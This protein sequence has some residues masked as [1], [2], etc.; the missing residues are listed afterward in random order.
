AV[1]ARTRHGDQPGNAANGKVLFKEF[2]GKCH[3]MQAAGSKG[4]IG[5]NLDTDKVAYTGVVSA[6]IQGVGGIQAEYLLRALTFSQIY[7]VAKFVT[8]SRSSTSVPVPVSRTSPFSSTTPC[9]L[10]FRPARA[11][12]STSRIV[13][14]CSFISRTVSK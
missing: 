8:T 2:C 3:V 13:R 12:C 6:V 9:E 7:D 14:P 1:G 11:F 5:P 4:T 10:S